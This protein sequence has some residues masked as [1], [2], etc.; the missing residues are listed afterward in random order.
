MEKEFVMIKGKKH[1]VEERGKNTI[2]NLNG[3]GITDITE[4]EG[5]DSLTNLYGLSLRENEI[6]ELKG[7]EQLTNL[8][9]LDLTYNPIKVDEQR[10]LYSWVGGE[11]TRWSKVSGEYITEFVEPTTDDMKD[12]QGIIKYCQDK[13]E[14]K[15]QFV[16]VRGTKYY[17]VDNTLYLSGAEIIDFNSI[18]GLEKLI[19]LEKLDLSNNEIREIEGLENLT[20]L[21]VL[22]LDK[23][24]I[25]EIRGLESLTNLRELYLNGNKIEE[26]KGLET[27]ANLKVLELWA[28]PLISDEKNIVYIKPYID[29]PYEVYHR[30]AQDLVKFCQDKKEGKL[31]FVTISGK[32]YYKD[33][34]L[35]NKGWGEETAEFRRFYV[36]NNILNL[37]GLEITE[38]TQIEGLEMLTNLK[39]LRL[40]NNSIK[41]IKGLETLKNLA[42]IY[43][44]HN[45]IKDIKGLEHLTKVQILDLGYNQIEEIKGLENL[46]HLRELYLN[47]NQIEEIKGLENLTNLQWLWL[48]GNQIRGEERDLIEVGKCGMAQK[49]VRYCQEQMR[50]Q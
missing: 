36:K 31:E 42:N 35:V 49:V 12:V 26:L 18:K 9:W 30:H 44:S 16:T 7:L 46:A 4:I 28:N 13:V 33:Y 47:N 1:Y 50:N 45:Q 21:K 43:L 34:Y 38:I 25:N 23:N 14:G 39:E 48:S 19:D 37:E 41:E 27:L 15:L 22:N 32:T 3:L 29:E 11:R 17:V 40:K 2:L 10:I 8:R 5:L 20:S 24:R 6:K